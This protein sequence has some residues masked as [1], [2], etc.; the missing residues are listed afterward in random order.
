M[1]CT[2]TRRADGH[3]PAFRAPAF[4]RWTKQAIAPSLA[5]LDEA[6][7][8]EGLERDAY[9]RPADLKNFTEPA[10][11]WLPRFP[12]DEAIARDGAMDNRAQTRMIPP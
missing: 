4:Q 11:T 2:Q 8:G 6:L 3:Q 12:D 10:F 5:D 9:G 7:L 1:R